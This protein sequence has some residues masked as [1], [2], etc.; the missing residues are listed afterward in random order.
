MSLLASLSIAGSGMSAESERLSAIASNI[1]N[2]NSQVGGNGQ[3]YRAREVVFQAA[4]VYGDDGDGASVGT[5]G[6]KVA[7]IV[8]S[9]A[10]T[11]SVYDPTSTFA[12]ANGYVQMPNV[13]PVDEMVNMISAQ[14]DYQANLEAFNV[15][16]TLAL[17]TL[18]I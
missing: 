3:E 4:S 9:D 1:A 18:T 8:E 15:V 2:A 13:N 10:P 11:H 6:V 5:D 12:D 14:Q 17:R 7:G 16:K